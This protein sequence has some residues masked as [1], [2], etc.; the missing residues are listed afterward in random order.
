MLLWCVLSVNNSAYRAFRGI[1]CN[2][3]NFI[4]RKINAVVDKDC[5][6]TLGR[7]AVVAN[8]KGAGW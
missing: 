6:S 2:I 8:R 1:Q 4:K 7:T 5:P 3:F